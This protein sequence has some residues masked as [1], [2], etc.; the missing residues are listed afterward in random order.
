VTPC[1]SPPPWPYIFSDYSFWVH[2]LI[3]Q[4]DRHLLKKFGLSE[5][6]TL[7]SQMTHQ[8]SIH[9][10]MSW[11]LKNVCQ[12]EVSVKKNSASLQT[13]AKT[14]LSSDL[15]SLSHPSANKAA[16]FIHEKF[17]G[18]TLMQKTHSMKL[19]TFLSPSLF[20][21]IH[22]LRWLVQTDVAF[23]F[24]PGARHQTYVGLLLVAPAPLRLPHE[25]FSI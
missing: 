8:R 21:P 24:M 10:S 25:N 3:N 23:Y 7:V 20:G 14:G 6:W 11:K 15:R 18:A 1:A 4:D 12:K 17:L 9:Y 16:F 13:S 2:H 19:T 22:L 5:V